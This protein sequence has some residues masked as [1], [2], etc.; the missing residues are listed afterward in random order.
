MSGLIVAELASAEDTR[1]GPRAAALRR[2]TE[3]AAAHV[4]AAQD[5][6]KTARERS[7]NAE[8][9]LYEFNTLLETH[10]AQLRGRLQTSA[11][12]A[13]GRL[14]QDIHAAQLHA[15]G[16]FRE[17]TRK[18]MGV[19]TMAPVQIHSNAA[20]VLQT[21]QSLAQLQE[22]AE[23]LQYEA[24]PDEQLLAM[25]EQLLHTLRGLPH[26]GDLPSDGVRRTTGSRA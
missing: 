13:I 25:V 9:D 1:T 23:A 21:R 16:S 15:L 26:V 2:A 6:L 5:A 7:G 14:L 12:P 3:D 19:S 24:L 11:H 4:V 8:R 10:V 20:S 22:R 18:P 17:W